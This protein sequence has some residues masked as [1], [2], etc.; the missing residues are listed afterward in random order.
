MKQFLKGALFATIGI[1]FFNAV[2]AVCESAGQLIDAKIAV[3]I[4][5]CNVKIQELANPPT[6]TRA[7]GFT[8][9]DEEDDYD[10]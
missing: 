3:K 8:I 6:E 7:I 10:E 5:E 4:Q 1:T 2:S 9:P